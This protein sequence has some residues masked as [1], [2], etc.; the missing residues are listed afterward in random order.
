MQ[1]D[2]SWF[3]LSFCSRSEDPAEMAFLVVVHAV[4]VGSPGWPRLSISDEYTGATHQTRVYD[5]TTMRVYTYVYIS[6]YFSM[7]TCPIAGGVRS[8]VSA[9]VCVLFL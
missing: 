5:C 4:Y 8:R 7:L 9:L 6:V 1:I 2:E 3:L